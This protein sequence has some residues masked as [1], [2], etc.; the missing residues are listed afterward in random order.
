[1]G[2]QMLVVELPI[3]LQKSLQPRR[4]R[5]VQ[6]FT[7]IELL[8]VIAVIAILASLLLP[9]LHKAKAQAQRA[10]CINNEKQLAITWFL[11]ASDNNDNVARN[12]YLPDGVPLDALLKVTKLWVLG[13]THLSP[14]YYTNVA[15]LSNPEEA[16]FASYLKTPG[17]YKCPA[18]RDKIHIGAGSFPRIRSYSMNS[19]IGWTAPVLPVGDNATVA[20]WNDPTYLAF[21]KTSDLALTDPASTFLFADMNPGSVCHSAFVVSPRW[22]YHLPFTGHGGSG[23]LTFSDSHVETHKWKDPRTIYPGYDLLNHLE[24]NARN[25]DLEWLLSHSSAPK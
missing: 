1:M 23:V 16:S 17:V 15:A 22:F 9:T 8:V 12:G 4:S 14:S 2:E 19:Y 13:A 21:N 5:F 6:G 11:Y 18:D 25:A 10:Q 7:L 20:P 24:G 3:F